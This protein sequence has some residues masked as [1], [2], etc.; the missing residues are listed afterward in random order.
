MSSFAIDVV[1]SVIMILLLLSVEPLW[2]DPVD[3]TTGADG[4]ASAIRVARASPP[5]H[6]RT[7][8]PNVSCGEEHTSFPRVA[9]MYAE[10]GTGISASLPPLA[11]SRFAGVRGGQIAGYLAKRG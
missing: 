9:N 2:L 3:P 10:R 1:S 4:S 11:A 6:S 5:E 7:L 8:L